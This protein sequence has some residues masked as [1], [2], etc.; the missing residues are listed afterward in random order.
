MSVYIYITIK[1]LFFEANI[2]LST[3]QY[4]A[5]PNEEICAKIKKKYTDR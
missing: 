2:G 1:V 3:L 4:F 5:F